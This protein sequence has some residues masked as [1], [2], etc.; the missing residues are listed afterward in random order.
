MSS[1]SPY[2]VTAA[3][4]EQATTL[5]FVPG[6]RPDRFQSAWRSQADVIILD[7]EAS[8]H[9]QSKAVARVEVSRWLKEAPP[10]VCV[11]VRMNRLDTEDGA[12]DWLEFS[13]MQGI[14]LMCPGAE[15]GPALEELLVRSR[16]T[17][18]VVLLV[19][20]AVGIEQAN[21]LAALPGVCR[22][23]FGNMDY[24]TELGLGQQPWGLVYPSSKLVV[25]SRCAKLPAPIAGVTASIHDRSAMD[26]DMAFERSLGFTAKMCIHPAQ[27]PRA[28][29]AFQPSGDEIA[30]AQLILEATSTS[31]AIQLDGQMIDRPV[32]ER[33]RLI[34]Q[35]SG[36]LKA[37]N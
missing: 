31:H 27:I 9:P 15:T 30:W 16:Q 10:G 18:P 8:V 19:E 20:T 14:G 2:E 12:L 32:I 13:S 4:L 17:K 21:Q 33:A 25:A 37:A 36:Q 3:R 29:E 26:A 7:L 11:L 6:N 1:K 22:L 34:L 28:K 5:L 23:A 24:A 35:R